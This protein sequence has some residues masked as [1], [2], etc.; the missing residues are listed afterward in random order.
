MPYLTIVTAEGPRRI[1][2]SPGGSLRDVLDATSFRVRSGCRGNGLCGLCLVQVEIE[3]GAVNPPTANEAAM[4]PGD[5]LHRGVRL[6]CQV[7]ARDDLSIRILNAAPSSAWR[8]LPAQAAPQAP[9]DIRRASTRC[10]GLAV[11][12]GPTHISL[13]LWDLQQGVRIA[14]RVGLNPQGQYGAD[15]VAR[16]IAAG[17]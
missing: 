12:L 7:I 8:G 14:G 10:Y 17:Q 13:A 11:D 1:A 3:A 4:L 15:V 2:F 16:L 5:Q 9:T 6:A